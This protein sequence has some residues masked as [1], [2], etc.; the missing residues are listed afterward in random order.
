M[1]TYKHV[2]EVVRNRCVNH[3]AN[4]VDSIATLLLSATS[5]RALISWIFEQTNKNI[6]IQTSKL[7]KQNCKNFIQL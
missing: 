2:T 4:I 7:N 3:Q 6:A 1:V 5:G